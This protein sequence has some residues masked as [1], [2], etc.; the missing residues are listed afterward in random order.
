MY[1]LSNWPF[2]SLY[3]INNIFFK[4]KLVHHEIWVRFYE[5]DNEIYEDLTYREYRDWDR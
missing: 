3:L 1:I 5:S 2:N 4:I